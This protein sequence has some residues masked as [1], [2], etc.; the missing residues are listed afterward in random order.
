MTLIIFSSSQSQILA[1]FWSKNWSL[2]HDDK[3]WMYFSLQ[4]IAV[5]EVGGFR[6]VWDSTNLVRQ[7]IYSP[8]TSEK[9]IN[10]M[11]DFSKP[12]HCF[13][14]NNCTV[15]SLPMKIPNDASKVRVFSK[16]EQEV[17]YLCTCNCLKRK[18][19]WI[20]QFRIYVTKIVKSQR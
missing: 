2:F 3:C 19:A 16:T 5:A 14:S 18:K 10:F 4:I 6:D 8:A 7:E 12:K 9:S 15:H 17:G 1:L 11:F 20:S 13:Q